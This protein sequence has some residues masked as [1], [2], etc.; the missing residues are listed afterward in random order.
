MQAIHVYIC[1][2]ESVMCGKIRGC[3]SRPPPF[4]LGGGVTRPGSPLLAPGS[5]A[6]RGWGEVGGQARGMKAGPSVGG[7]SPG[8]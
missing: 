8:S 5:T 4:P 7:R 6:Q 2:L 1:E 3:P